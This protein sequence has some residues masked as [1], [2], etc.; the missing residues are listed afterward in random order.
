V[1]RGSFNRTLPMLAFFFIAA[2]VETPSAPGGITSNTQ[3]LSSSGLQ[4]RPERTLFQA[5]F[6]GT[7]ASG[8]TGDFAVLSNRKFTFTYV[9]DA[10]TP[11]ANP[12]DP[13][14]GFYPGAITDG[15][16]TVAGK[17]GSVSWTAN[18]FGSNNNI[19]IQRASDRHQYEAGVDLVGPS[20]G[21]AQPSYLLLQLIDRDRE[22]FSSDG[23]PTSIDLAAFEW[24]RNV[25]ITFI[26]SNPF[27]CSTLGTVEKAV[28]RPIR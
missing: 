21:G 9:F 7:T 5:Q 15:Q 20:I 25:Q 17:G 27:C 11:D 26:G 22:A 14:S 24:T 18:P 6:T 3:L 16:F 12:G 1:T 4:A 10:T 13:N 28:I 19:L 8:L 23:L 2:C